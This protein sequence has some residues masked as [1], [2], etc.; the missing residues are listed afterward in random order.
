M[1]LKSTD[2]KLLELFQS[3]GGVEKREC[4]KFL[5]SPY[6]NQR[7]DVLL[8]WQVL[9][10][11]GF[12]ELDPTQCYSKVYPGE[13]FDAAKW[14]HIQS[15]LI[16]RMERFLAQ[17]AFEQMPLAA[18]LHLAPVLR[19]NKLGKSHSYILQRIGKR[20]AQLPHDQDFYHWEYQLEWEKYIAI[21][22]H[23]R[24]RENNLAAVAH[25]LDV[26]LLASK[27]RLACLMESHQA[28]FN[29]DY[30]QTYLPALMAYLE[31]SKLREVPLVALYYYCYRALIA[32]AEDDFRAFR[33]Q[34]EQQSAQLP[35]EERRTFLLLAVNFCIRRLNTGAQQYIREA[36]DLYRV[37]LET[38]ALLEQGYLS[39]FAY[40]N[41]V[42]LGLRL[43]EFAWVETFI[44]NYEIHLEEKYRMA[45]RDYNLA[46]L[47]FTQKD[48]Q[49][50]M[51]LLAQVDESD[52]LLN[53]DS[54]VMLLKMYFETGE[55]D[56]LDALIASFKVLLL[57][58]KKVIGYHQS[59]YLNT[60]RYIQKLTRLNLNDKAAVA[61]FR[62]EV[63]RN[64]AVLEKDW[65]LSH[66]H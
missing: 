19:K 21:E 26:Y 43:K 4:T 53:L 12:T 63:E 39:R 8:L 24:S 37:G 5:N 38:D 1:I 55:W 51:P 14:R 32:G 17:R 48:Y 64:T 6:F 29:T 56:A 28:V 60:L 20:M 11:T 34:L 65:L 58:K 9:L 18:D 30:D 15:F 36:F 3:L 52:L 45:N 25:A 2:N 27:L 22:S 42:A 16:S 61:N 62:Q 7:E 40:K 41:I 33:L 35:A 50:A 46:R 59:H 47:Y 44:K 23:T 66:A 57:R 54:R 10:D 13:A 31:H 49:R